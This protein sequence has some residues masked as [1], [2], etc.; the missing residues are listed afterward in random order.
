MATQNTTRKCD[1]CQKPTDN[2]IFCPC[3][4]FHHICPECIEDVGHPDCAYIVGELYRPALNP[5]GSW[6]VVLLGDNG[7]YRPL[8]PCGSEDEARRLRSAMASDA[9]DFAERF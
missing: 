1:R 9:Q 3:D 7:V 2:E 5:D 6:W 8:A 4:L